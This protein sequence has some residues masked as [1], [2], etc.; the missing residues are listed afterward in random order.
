MLPMS[1]QCKN[2]GDYMFIGTKVNCR[3]ELCYN[4]FYLGINVY[5]IYM[6]CKSCY[7][8]ITLK[9]DPKNCDYIVEQGATRHF[10]PWRDFYISQAMEEK[11][12]M[13]G[14]VMEKVEESTVDTQI[15]MEQLRELERLRAVSNKQDK[16]D[17]DAVK[18]RIE[19]DKKLTSDDDAKLDNFE[20]EQKKLRLQM[21]LNRKEEIKPMIRK[22][23]KFFNYGNVVD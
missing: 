10:E 16:V 21:C 20:S 2:C 12:K 4:E 3:K 14:T 19:V 22:S 15:E 9:T 6:H 1:L 5:R 23:S 17:L 7:A 13:L 8:E 18:S 11:R